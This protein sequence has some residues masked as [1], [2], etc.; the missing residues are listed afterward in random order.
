M[1]NVQD[2]PTMQH[3]QRQPRTRGPVRLKF[4]K[5]TEGM[6]GEEMEKLWLKVQTQDYA[7]DDFSRGSR[8][9]F[10]MN[11]VQ[12]ASHHVLVDDSAYCNVRNVWPESS[13]DIHFV[14]WDRTYPFSSLLEAGKQMLDWLFNTQQVHRVGAFIPK[15][16]PLATR[17][18]TVMGFKWEGTLRECTKFHDQFID[19]DIS[20]MLKQQ[21]ERRQ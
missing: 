10:V 4:L 12:P 7:F 15:N 20:S 11:L 21:F 1:D 3:S 13:C 2:V 5:P 17:F 9:A 18:A 8:Q 6:T 14:C 16:N 19:V